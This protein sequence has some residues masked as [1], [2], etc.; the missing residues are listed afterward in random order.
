MACIFALY[1]FVKNKNL[2]RHIFC[3]FLGCQTACFTR[4]YSSFQAFAR[5]FMCN[6]TKNITYIAISMNTMGVNA[7]PLS[8][9][10]ALTKQNTPKSESM[11]INA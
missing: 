5:F 3:L 9:S 7:M 10:A 4:L 2:Q 11:V 1:K 6:T 8:Y